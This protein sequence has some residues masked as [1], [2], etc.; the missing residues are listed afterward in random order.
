M[1]KFK[2]TRKSSRRKQTAV[3]V[4]LAFVLTNTPMAVMAD[5]T[6]GGG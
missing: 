1:F 3:L 2:K 4:L 6:N 5:S